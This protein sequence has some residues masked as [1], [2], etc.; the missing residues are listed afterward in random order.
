VQETLAAKKEKEREKNI[1]NT[2]KGDGS[3]HKEIKRGVQRER[4]QE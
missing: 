3:S 1:K 2:K 4:K